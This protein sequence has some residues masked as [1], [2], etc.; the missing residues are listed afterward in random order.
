[1]FSFYN[2][3][4]HETGWGEGNENWMQE[5]RYNIYFM[6]QLCQQRSV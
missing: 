6:I 2:G 3:R 4:S 5:A 1:M